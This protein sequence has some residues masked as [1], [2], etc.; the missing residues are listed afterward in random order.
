[1]NRTINTVCAG[2]STFL[3][4][5]PPNVHA[6]GGYGGFMFACSS[7]PLVS[8]SQ[9]LFNIPLKEACRPATPLCQRINLRKACFSVVDGAQTI[10]S[11]RTRRDNECATAAWVA[12]TQL[13]IY[14]LPHHHDQC[15]EPGIFNKKVAGEAMFLSTGA[16]VFRHVGSGR[17]SRSTNG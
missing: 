11:T 12:A 1:M 2:I 9:L 17:T 7:L 14:V 16:L 15:Q 4:G 3:T 6:V 8:C 5:A 13:F 10:Q